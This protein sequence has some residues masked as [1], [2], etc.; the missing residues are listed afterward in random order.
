MPY[1]VNV[2]H[3]YA[4][5]SYTK[6]LRRA[7]RD[8]CFFVKALEGSTPLTICINNKSLV[9]SEMVEFLVKKMRKNKEFHKF[10]KNCLLALTRMGV[11]HLPSLYNELFTEVHYKQLPESCAQDLRLPIVIRSIHSYKVD[12]REFFPSKYDGPD[13]SIEFKQFIMKQ[14]LVIGSQDSIHTL[15]SILDCPRKEIFRSEYINMMINF[16]WEQVWYVMMV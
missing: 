7:L 16:K 9:I 4:Y 11:Q 2:M 6:Y 1:R 15:Q 13:K 5:M 12:K 8:N 14:S 3:L 10:F